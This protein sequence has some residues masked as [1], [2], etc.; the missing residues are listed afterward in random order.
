MSRYVFKLPD[1]GEGT[2]SS[3][4]VAWR[5]Q[6]GDLVREDGPLVEMSTEKAVIEV[7]SPVT[8]RV[9]ALRGEPGDVVA[10]GAEL[11][12]FETDAV[13]VV[14]AAASVSQRQGFGA[15]SSPAVTVQAKV[16]QAQ[17]LGGGNRRAFFA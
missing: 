11:V 2:V 9:V 3:E 6:V 10:V 15:T 7:P 13:A 14:A 4:I 5:V 8:G 16:S 17:R 12:V 1:L